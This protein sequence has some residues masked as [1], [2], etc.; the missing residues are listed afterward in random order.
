MEPPGLSEAWLV[1]IR[2][3]VGDFMVGATTVERARTQ[4]GSPGTE[5][6][7]ASMLNGGCETL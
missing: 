3:W 5:C 1:R 7:Q 4:D 6:V 2:T